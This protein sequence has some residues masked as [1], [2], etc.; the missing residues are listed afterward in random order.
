MQTYC[1][2]NGY[3]CEISIQKNDIN[4]S[5]LYALSGWH[6]QHHPDLGILT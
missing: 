2:T 6:S 1:I 5:E 4:Y 3:E